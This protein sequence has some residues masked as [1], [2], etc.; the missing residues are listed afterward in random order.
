MGNF[1]YFS[2]K[3]AILQKPWN[4][5]D[6]VI[7]S[8]RDMSNSSI[9]SSGWYKGIVISCNCWCMHSNTWKV[10]TLQR[11]RGL[12]NAMMTNDYP[13]AYVI[14]DIP[15]WL[16]SIVHI[17][18]YDSW[19]FWSICLHICLH[20]ALPSAIVLLTDCTKQQEDMPMCNRYINLWC[21][22]TLLINGCEIG[23]FKPTQ[24]LF[25]FENSLYE[26]MIYFT[27]WF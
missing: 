27:W 23:V 18:R 1:D 12:H 6:C 4:S 20:R 17:N 25:S 15:P 24:G 5:S 2:S 22:L 13:H 16:W 14:T 11:I 7:N 26:I 10:V 3:N 9:L 21:N 8:H 19:Q